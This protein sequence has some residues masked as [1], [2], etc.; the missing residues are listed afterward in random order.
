MRR[1]LIE[2]PFAGYID[3]A[4]SEGREVEWRSLGGVW[5]GA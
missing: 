4:I 1:V 3:R 5:S 2:S